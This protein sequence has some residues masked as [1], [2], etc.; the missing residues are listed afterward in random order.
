MKKEDFLKFP[1]RVK[2]GIRRAFKL[3]GIKDSLINEYLSEFEDFTF[4]KTKNRSYIGRLNYSCKMTE[5]YA[6]RFNFNQ[7]E[8]YQSEIAKKLAIYQPK[9]IIITF[10]LMSV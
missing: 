3:E 9:K 4:Q 7:K 8:V 5:R 10:I 2:E 1:E 6:D